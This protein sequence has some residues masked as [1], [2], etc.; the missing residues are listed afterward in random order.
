MIGKLKRKR[1]NMNLD[2]NR[3]VDRYGPQEKDFPKEYN[4]ISSPYDMIKD[5]EWQEKMTPRRFNFK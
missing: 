2:I 1:I 4:D 3:H 5:P